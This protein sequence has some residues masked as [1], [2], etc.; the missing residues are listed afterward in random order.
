[1][2]LITEQWLN[3]V[4]RAT[5]QKLTSFQ[6]SIG[7]QCIQFHI[8]FENMLTFRVFL[9]LSSIQII[10]YNDFIILF[11]IRFLFSPIYAK[12]NLSIRLNCIYLITNLAPTFFQ[13]YYER[14]YITFHFPNFVS[15]LCTPSPHVCPQAWWTWGH[16]S[17]RVWILCEE[18]IF[19]FQVYFHYLM[20]ALNATFSRPQVW[21]NFDFL[22]TYRILDL[23]FCWG[24]I[25]SSSSHV[26]RVYHAVSCSYLPHCL[27]K[28]WIHRA[29]ALS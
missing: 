20:S 21:C 1:M 6:N 27:E 16:V 28:E 10:K 11:K 15:E 13:R 8:E 23:Y 3:R 5:C 17:V 18:A 12:E 4:S 14:I 7:A 9:I 26:H 2:A 25:T 29:P 24:P 22:W 19:I